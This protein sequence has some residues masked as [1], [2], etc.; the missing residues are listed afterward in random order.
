MSDE[1]LTARTEELLRT[2]AR[3]KALWD[4]DRSI[5]L[6]QQPRTSEDFMKQALEMRKAAGLPVSNLKKTSSESGQM[7]TTSLVESM[8]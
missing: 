3:L 8:S 2:D 7:P 4:K 6:N 5:R 1:P